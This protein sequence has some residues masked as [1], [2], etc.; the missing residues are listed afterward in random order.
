MNALTSSN[1]P[2]MNLARDYA[3]RD[4]NKRGLMQSSIAVGAA[5]EAAIRNALPIAQQDAQSQF[6]INNN[7]DLHRF[8]MAK[9]ASDKA[10]TQKEYTSMGAASNDRYAQE[11]TRIQE[12]SLTPE[13]KDSAV[14]ALKQWK[15]ANDNWLNFAFKHVEGIQLNLQP[16]FTD[17]STPATPAA[18]P[19]VT[20]SGGRVFTGPSGVEAIDTAALHADAARELD[21]AANSAAR[22]TSG[23]AVIDGIARQAELLGLG[24]GVTNAVNNARNQWREIW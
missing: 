20:Q 22:H 6:T 21:Q 1:S 15:V 12:S 19:A 13:Q 24:D 2:Y 3:L 14:A 4:M 16:F 23:N 11:F 9:T 17:T 8:D 10:L 18:T 5:H 7:A